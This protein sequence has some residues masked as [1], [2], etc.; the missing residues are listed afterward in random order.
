MFRVRSYMLDVGSGKVPTLATL[1][2]LAE[3]LAKFGYTELQLRMKGTPPI[4]PAEICELDAWCG[5]FGIDL[6]AGLDAS[7][8]SDDAFPSLLDGLLPNFVSRFVNVGFGGEPPVEDDPFLPDAAAQAIGADRLL[9]VCETVCSRGCRPMFCAD[10]LEGCP[11]VMR[12][13]PKGAVVVVCGYEGNHK[14][15]DEARRFASS[16]MDWIV[17]GGTSAWNSLAGR[18][19][20]V[21][22]NLEEAERAG[23]VWRSRGFMVADWGGFGHWQPLAAS[24]PAIILGGSLAQNGP[25]ASK[26]DLESALDDVMGVP[27]GGTLLRLGTLYLRGGATRAGESEL[28]RILS[29]DRG[30]SRHPGLT[31]S[32]VSEVSAVA[33]GCRHSAA[34]F[35]S[36]TLYGQGAVWA[37]EIVYMANLVDAACHRR[38]E[39]RL[40]AL[41][42]EHER[43]WLLRNRPDG[44]AESSTKLPR[45]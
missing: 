33:E 27:L 35:I 28:F 10:A 12:K 14:F 19:E 18:I 26:M 40:R 1:K 43:V 29:H 16:G 31:D 6:V 13:L 44:L 45:Y 4:A 36:P 15:D 25:R 7:A 5:S 34:A 24:L 8:V 17:C 9:R 11:E 38:D 20:N 32:V 23:R 41:R 2:W 30:Y 21:R 42:A 22:E 39:G 3:L 37:Q